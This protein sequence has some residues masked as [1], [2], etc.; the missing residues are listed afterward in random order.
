MDNVHPYYKAGTELEAK[1]CKYAAEI[2]E[3]AVKNRN[4][5]MLSPAF[6]GRNCIKIS[7][8]STSC[9]SVA[10]KTLSPIIIMSGKVP[11]RHICKQVTS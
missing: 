6:Q 7:V 3:I 2:M 11:N 4:N 5:N 8:A 1:S 10:P 9:V